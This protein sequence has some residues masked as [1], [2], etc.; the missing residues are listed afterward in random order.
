M[1]TPGY[2]P[3]VCRLLSEIF[4]RLSDG[5]VNALIK[6]LACS[7]DEYAEDLAIRH[8]ARLPVGVGANGL[9]DLDKAKAFLRDL[10]L[11]Q[12]G[13]P[14]EMDEAGNVTRRG[15]GGLQT[16]GFEEF[17][18]CASSPEQVCLRHANKMLDLVEAAIRMRTEEGRVA[19]DDGS[20]SG[21]SHGATSGTPAVHLDLDP[22]AFAEAMAAQ[23]KQSNYSEYE[24]RA[25]KLESAVSKAY[26]ENFYSTARRGSV[27]RSLLPEHDLG[28]RHLSIAARAL[29]AGHHKDDSSR[30]PRIPGHAE[31]PFHKIQGPNA[32]YLV[33]GSLS[34]APV[35]SQ[36][37]SFLQFAGGMEAVAL[38]RNMP[39][40]MVPDGVGS[41]GKMSAGRRY[42]F[43]HQE[44]IRVL[45]EKEFAERYPGSRAL[46]IA[47]NV[48]RSLQ[49]QM[50]SLSRQAIDSGAGNFDES[51]WP[52]L[53]Q[54]ANSVRL[55]MFGGGGGG[56]GGSGSGSGDGDSG[57]SG[58]GGGGVGG[59]N[60]PKPTDGY[61]S[62][63]AAKR[64]KA[65]AV[66]GGGGGGSGGNGGGNGGGQ[67]NGGNR[68]GGN[69]GGQRNGGNG[70]GG[71]GIGVGV[72][73]RFAAVAPRVWASRDS[74][75]AVSAA[76]RAAS[77]VAAICSTRMSWSDRCEAWAMGRL[78]VDD[79]WSGV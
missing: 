66:G 4:P 59:S 36:V 1:A 26:V 77:R 68:G 23:T 48:L 35:V 74:A 67:R 22:E 14:D 43:F 19:H 46:A 29:A 8:L 58:S 76:I 52:Q 57:G 75:I 40:S 63:R 15:V 72:S 41:G 20:G 9:G 56:G 5:G 53:T 18:E 73:R 42:I 6:V 45:T 44:L 30:E 28:P 55:G 54:T 78:R 65:L 62:R 2:S 33:T 24:R 50:A 61:P 16:E 17:L 38:Q 27:P 70:G 39:S 25:P 11:V 51:M 21:S 32:V 3:T 69:G 10:H 31:C 37:H 79:A 47:A 7:I 49:D 13:I 60:G 34:D 12:Y 71:G 64:A